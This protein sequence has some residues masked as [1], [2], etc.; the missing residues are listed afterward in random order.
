MSG[1]VRFT[2]AE[3]D[4][5]PPGRPLNSAN[6]R[7]YHC[8]Y[9]DPSRGMEVP[10]GIRVAWLLSPGSPDRSE[11]SSGDDTTASDPE[12]AHTV[13]RRRPSYEDVGN[14]AAFVA[15]D[16]ASTMTATEVNLTGGAVVD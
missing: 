1:T 9:S 2:F 4:G 14:A 3:M 16:W 5:T 8:Q 13:L 12:A 6:R 10:D 15:S 7:A 11:T